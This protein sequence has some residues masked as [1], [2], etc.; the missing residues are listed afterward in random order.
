MKTRV[1][2]AVLTLAVAPFAVAAEEENP[3]K[4]AKVGD[5]ATYKMVTKVLGMNI[6]GTVTQTVTAKDDKEVTV[7]TTGSAG[8]MEFP[9]QEQKI[10]LTK[11]FDPTKAGKLPAGADVKVEKLKDGT[12]KLKLGS[13]EHATKWETYKLKMKQMGVEFEAEMK[14]WQN[15]ELNIPVVKMEMTADVAGNKMEVSMELT[16][17]GNKEPEKKSKDKDK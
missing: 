16:E 5:Y 10:D 2:A 12:E 3:Y 7:K 6:E 11:P 1:F 4:K 13:K 9:A 15:K 17:T 14:I 8:D